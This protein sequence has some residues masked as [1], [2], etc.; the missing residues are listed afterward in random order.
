MVKSIGIIGMSEGNGHP[1]SYSSIINGYSPEG[2]AASGW[3]GIY[4]YV[5]RR[6]ASEFGI[7]GWSITHAWTQN[8]ETTQKLCAACRIPNIVSDYQDLLGKVD[9][10]IIARDDY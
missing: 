10:V 4:E 6:H 8:L 9:A 5:R 2:L 7:C 1:F 3:N